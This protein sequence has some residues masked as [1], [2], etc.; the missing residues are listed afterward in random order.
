MGIHLRELKYKRSIVQLTTHSKDIPNA[1]NATTEDTAIEEPGREDT[2]Y[3]GLPTGP[4]QRTNRRQNSPFQTRTSRYPLRI[5]PSSVNYVV[6]DPSDARPT[7]KT[8]TKRTYRY[9]STSDTGSNSGNDGENGRSFPRIP[10][11]FSRPPNV[12]VPETPRDISAGCRGAYRRGVQDRLERVCQEKENAK[13]VVEDPLPVTAQTTAHVQQLQKNL[14][15][16]QSIGTGTD[17]PPFPLPPK[18]LVWWQKYG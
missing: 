4:E 5:I 13:K 1:S 8:S 14:A 12:S 2:D 11:S 3:D 18:W 6:M 7:S 16:Y 17:P 10:P 9:M 15:A